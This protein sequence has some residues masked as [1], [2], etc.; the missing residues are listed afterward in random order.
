MKK[1]MVRNPEM[2]AKLWKFSAISFVTLRLSGYQ[3]CLLLWRS[4]SLVPAP[5]PTTLEYYWFGL[6]TASKLLNSASD[7]ARPLLLQHP[8]LCLAILNV[9]PSNGMYCDQVTASFNRK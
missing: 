8:A 6:F 9:I 2:G 7:E 3:F 1:A 5:G 4:G